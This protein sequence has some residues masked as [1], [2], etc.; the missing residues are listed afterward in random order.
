MEV[1]KDW[2]SAGVTVGDKEITLAAFYRGKEIIADCYRRYQAEQNQEEYCD[3]RTPDCWGCKHLK[4]IILQHGEA[5]YVAHAKYWYQFGEFTNKT[6]WHI[7]KD[8][9]TKA[10][11]EIVERKNIDFCP[12]FHFKFFRKFVAA[13]PASIDVTDTKNWGLTYMDDA[14]LNTAHWEAIGIYHKT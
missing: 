12:A 7:H 11:T 1:I 3:D 10:L 8:K 14:I 5:P 2:D 4:G 6:I 13:L 9:L